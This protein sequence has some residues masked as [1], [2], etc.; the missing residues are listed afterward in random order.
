MYFMVY[1]IFQFL[2]RRRISSCQLA[3]K[4]STDSNIDYVYGHDEAVISRLTHQ[5]STSIY[6]KTKSSDESSYYGEDVEVKAL[7]LTSDDYI[8]RRMPPY[9]FDVPYTNISDIDLTKYS[10]VSIN[11]VF[12]S[13]SKYC[14]IQSDVSYYYLCFFYCLL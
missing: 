11:Q 9:T 7:G 1:D 10:N 14:K 3:P 4:C 13:N 2:H 8:E 12:G 5:E 6:D